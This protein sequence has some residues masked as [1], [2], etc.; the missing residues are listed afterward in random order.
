M[1]NKEL[2]YVVGSALFFLVLI[3]V[4]AVFAVYDTR[5]DNVAEDAPVVEES[6]TVQVVYE[7]GVYM[8]SN[9]EG[10]LLCDTP[11]GKEIYSLV[12][13]SHFIVYDVDGYYGAVDFKNMKGW[14]DLRDCEKVPDDGE[15][16]GFEDSC[17]IDIWQVN[18]NHDPL[19]IR[20]EPSTDAKIIDKLD[21]GTI[22]EITL[23]DGKWGYVECTLDGECEPG[24]VD[25]E[26]CVPYISMS[27][28]VYVT[29]YG[30]KY[31]TKDCR[32]IQD[33]ENV[34]LWHWD[35]AEEKYDAC[36]VCGGW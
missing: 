25:T 3:I 10:I 19:N 30:K 23:Y 2:R 35:D 28:W 16:Y 36:K 22:I 5:D 15:Y 4:L 11:G 20:D 8:V 33:S 6:E 12:D 18:T 1:E 27:G 7:E 29:E 17:G 9:D 34:Y 32:T 24:W 14:V 26:H 21:K 31:H 13:H